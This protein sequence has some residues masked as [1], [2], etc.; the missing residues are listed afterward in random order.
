MGAFRPISPQAA[1][2]ILDAADVG[3]NSDQRLLD[4]AIAGVVKGYA[5]LIET[6]APGQPRHEVRDSKIRRDLWRRIVHDHKVTEVYSAG[7]VHLEGDAAAG[8]LGRISVIGIR[9]DETSV[10]AAAAEHGAIAP[11]LSPVETKSRYARPASTPPIAPPV[12]DTP[13]AFPTVK[14]RPM[15]E[16]GAVSISI[17]DA[18]AA[19]GVSRGTVYK[20]IDQG[21]LVAVKIG[22]RRLVRVDSIRALLDGAGFHTTGGA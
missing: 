3:A 11:A 10:H 9:F 6:A 18:A 2:Q 20:L 1:V 8:D 7:S 16:E 14:R 19:I 15:I 17:D 13:P 21:Q 22:N 12:A 5:R 4:F